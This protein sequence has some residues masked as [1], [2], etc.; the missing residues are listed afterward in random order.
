MSERDV[1]IPFMLKH[2]KGP[3]V[4]D[5]G[6]DRSGY[7]ST[8][9]DMGHT[10]DGVDPA[11]PGE[12]KFKMVFA[13]V[14]ETEKYDSVLLISSMEHF[15]PTPENTETCKDDIETISKAIRMLNPDGRII[16]TVPCGES[17]LHVWGSSPNVGADFIHY[18]L[19]KLR[20]IME[21]C[22][23]A[24]VI[25]EISRVFEKKWSTIE[26]APDARYG[27]HGADNA[28]AVYMGVWEKGIE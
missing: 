1:E 16:I 27:G 24:P 21:K 4:L 19:E 22:G 17:Y 28:E 20:Y 11:P 3:R 15:Y 12:C 2:V 14:P 7:T 18:S 8:L 26:S 10:V 13:H 25:Q 6:V 9:C 5:V 23:V